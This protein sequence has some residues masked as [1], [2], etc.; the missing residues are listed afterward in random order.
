[1]KL[2]EYI[3][4]FILG[5]LATIIVNYIL[6]NYEHGPALTAYLYITPTIYLVIMY[7]V[8][9]SAGINGYY[10]FLMHSLINTMYFIFTLFFLILLTRFTNWDVYFNFSLSIL[11]FILYSIYYFYN[12]FRLKFNAI[13]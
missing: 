6:D 5:G 1:M 13:N 11:L 4:N 2:K 7:I 12:I 10:T 3:L 9:K 8:Y